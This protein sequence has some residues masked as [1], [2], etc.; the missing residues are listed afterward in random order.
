MSVDAVPV[1]DIGRP[2]LEVG[3]HDPE[4]FLNP[5]QSVVHVVDLPCRHAELRCDKQV[6]PCEH[7]V[8][9]DLLLVED[10]IALHLLAVPLEDDV[11][12]RIAVIFLMGLL[13]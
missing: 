7:F 13:V 5:P 12:D 11:L 10:C 4:T 9:F 1:S 2:C 6:V 3:L 8:L